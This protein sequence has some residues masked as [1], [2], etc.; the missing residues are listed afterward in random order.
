MK[1]ASA[2]AVALGEKFAYRVAIPNEDLVPPHRGR[3]IHQKI[4]KISSSARTVKLEDGS[5]VSYDILV[6]ATGA[7][8]NS[9]CE[10]TLK[11]RNTRDI[12]KWYKYWNDEIEKVKRVTIL[13]GGVV[14]TEMAAEIKYH[15]PSKIVSL[16]SNEHVLIDGG[17]PAVL[18]GF[19]EKLKAKLDKLG[20]RL[21][22]GQKPINLR[23]KDFRGRCFLSGYRTIETSAAEQVRSDLILL[24]NGKTLNNKM[25]P[26]EWM[27]RQGQ[28]NVSNTLQLQ[29]NPNVFAI[30]DINSAKVNKQAYT[31]I[32]QAELAATNVKK[33]MQ[34]KGLKS[35]A[36]SNF[37]VLSL[38]VGR[39][40]GVTQYGPVVFGDRVTRKW[41][42][43]ELQISN[44][45]KLY[46]QEKAL[47]RENEENWVLMSQSMY[48][49][50]A[51]AGKPAPTYNGS[52]PYGASDPVPRRNHNQNVQ[53][54][55]YM[56]YDN[57]YGPP[58]NPAN[59]G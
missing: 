20:V 42:G 48:P 23:E 21:Y 18:P 25:Y 5:K 7:L 35:Y 1:C 32:K 26:S 55:H 43:E 49:A 39:N 47:I 28:L 36:P 38:P 14:G 8:S 50:S 37:T 56:N 33:L 31:A 16:I 22:L 15:N 10:P 41:K 19:N 52:T 40:K 4:K 9:A 59:Y 45:W 24:C 29:V 44:R 11:L 12:V 2:R 27:N 3:V 30:G 34:T 17:S 57:R 53:M 54:N 13:G 6:C 58:I 51:S 46:N